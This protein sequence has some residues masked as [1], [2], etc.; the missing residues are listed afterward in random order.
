V[1]PSPYQLAIYDWIR[2]GSGSA[3]VI[4]V[5]GSGKTHTILEGLSHIPTHQSVRLFAYNRRIADTLKGRI[6]RRNVEASTYHSS[7]YRAILAELHARVETDKGKMR[8]LLRETLGETDRR[9]YGE[10]LQKLVSQAK[11]VGMGA[12]LPDTTE[13]W[14]DLIETYELDFSWLVPPRLPDDDLDAYLRAE[15]A[16]VIDLA[17]ELLAASNRAALEP[18]AWS[19]DFDDQLYLPILWKLA[20]P[21]YDWV[22][23]DEAQDTNVI[24]RAFIRGSLKDGGRVLVVGDPRQAIYAWRGATHNAMD[25]LGEEF[26][27]QTFPLSVCYRCGR[28]IVEKA[29][30]LV[31]QIEAWPEGIEG[32]VLED[33]PLS[34][35]PTLPSSSV[36]LCRTNAPLVKTAY[37]LIAAGIGVRVLGRDIG[38]DLQKLIR[39]LHPESVED[40]ETKLVNYKL[41]EV[42]RHRRAGDDAKADR[43][44]DQ[45]QCLQ[46]IIEGAG[47]DEDRTL[48]GI[49]E[50]IDDLFGD[51][52]AERL[53]L[54]TI[55][56]AKGEEWPVVAIIRHW[57]I[58]IRWAKTE[59]AIQ[60][61]MNLLYVAYTRAKE[62]LLIMDDKPEWVKRK[63]R[64]EAREEGEYGGQDY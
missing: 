12:L 3:S 8:T 14:E 47:S 15:K 11:G 29:Q 30:S 52:D 18:Y 49:E 16:R 9:A 6:H 51:R 44:T 60:Q 33:V 4:A 1:T 19:I 20:L 63:E 13:L 26:D 40:L 28:R 10:D 57:Q 42:A 36:I 38:E 53:T 25:L 58:P 2:D 45:V 56:K 34:V 41:K 21:T 22:I 62:R 59:L 7:G 55:H 48:E 37:Q 31:P 27:C 64:G 46:V 24:Q 23:V 61:E 32:E 39:K 17:R 54:S 43:V 5:A 50:A 35:L